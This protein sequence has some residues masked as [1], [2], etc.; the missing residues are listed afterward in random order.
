MVRD[1]RQP[2]PKGKPLAEHLWRLCGAARKR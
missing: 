1:F 2:A